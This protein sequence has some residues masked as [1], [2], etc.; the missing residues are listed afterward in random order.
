MKPLRRGYTPCGGEIENIKTAKF[1][2]KRE[3]LVF[4]IKHFTFGCKSGIIE[5]RRAIVFFLIEKNEV[6]TGKMEVVW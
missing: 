2:V 4:S 5:N 6:R 3:F 1:P